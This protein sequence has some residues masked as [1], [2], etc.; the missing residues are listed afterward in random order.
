MCKK[1]KL[2]QCKRFLSFFCH[3]LQQYCLH[4]ILEN[5]INKNLKKKLKPIFSEV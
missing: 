3:S 4:E 2:K 5:L 1:F